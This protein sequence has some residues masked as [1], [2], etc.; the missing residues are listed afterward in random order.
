MYYVVVCLRSFTKST[1]SFSAMQTYQRMVQSEASSAD[2]ID[3]CDLIC[4]LW[5]YFGGPTVIHWK[6]TLL[7]L[8]YC[9]DL[10]VC[11]F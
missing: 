9:M 1:E 7:T 4:K 3:F 8:F 2:Q 11:L 6:C 5:L 10:M